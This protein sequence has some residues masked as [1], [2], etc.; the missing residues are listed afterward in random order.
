MKLVDLLDLANRGY[1]DGFLAEYY[2]SR[3][4][5]LKRGSGDTLA[6]FIVKELTDT[7]DSEADDELQIATAV[8][9][10]E[11][12][13]GDLEDAIAAVNGSPGRSSSDDRR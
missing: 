7:F 1:P 2:D 3:T 5:D 8:H 10:L 4:G 9:M 6:E 12:A 13:V 11:R